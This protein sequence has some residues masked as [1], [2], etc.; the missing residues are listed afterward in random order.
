M[1]SAGE[2]Q[3][4]AVAL[5]DAFIAHIPETWTVGFLYDIACQIHASAVKHKL[6]EGYLHRLRFAVS[7]FHAYGHDWPCQ[8]V[9]HPRKRVGFGLTDGEGCERFWYSISR[10]I[11]YLRVAGVGGLHIVRCLLTHLQFYLRQYTLNSQFNYATMNSL[12]GAAA[13]IARKRG[14][15]RAKQRDS[16]TQLDECGNIG[17]RPKFL[18]EQWRLQIAHQMQ[19]APRK[20]QRG[21]TGAVLTSR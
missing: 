15:L 2:E 7:V 14:L 20:S 19:E 12:E 8:L 21:Q 3:Y 18:R 5:M 4:Y 10:L 1:T 13:W 17:K 6:F 9:Y 11:P 16:Q